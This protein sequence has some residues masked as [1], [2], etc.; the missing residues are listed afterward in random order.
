MKNKESKLT[1]GLIIEN[2]YTEFA[3]DVINSIVS[4]V[5]KNKDIEIVVIAGKYVDIGHEDDMQS[6]YKNVYNSIYRLEEL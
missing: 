4:S 2:V 5:P 1:I 3:K 6:R